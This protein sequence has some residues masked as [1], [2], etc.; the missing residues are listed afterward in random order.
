MPKKTEQLLGGHAVMCVGYKTIKKKL[1]FIV[2][3]SWGSSWGDRGYFYMPAAY[4]SDSNLCDDFWTIS[5][6]S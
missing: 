4:I 6:V 1:Y 3:N 2:R 5:L